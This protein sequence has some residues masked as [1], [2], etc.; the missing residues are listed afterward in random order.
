ML[1]IKI[2]SNVTDPLYHQITEQVKCL[3]NSNQLKPGE[4]IPS[5]RDLATWL[6]L[7]PSTVA[8]AYYC[9]KQE[10]LVVTSR[11]R[12]TVICGRNN[13]LSPKYRPSEIFENYTLQNIAVT[14]T[15]QPSLWHV[16]KS[17]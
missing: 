8:K 14:F 2:D 15:L 6:Q 9:L 13:Q 16:Q 10:G 3:I 12:G 11:R 7:N 17:E 5:V 4:Q 1:E